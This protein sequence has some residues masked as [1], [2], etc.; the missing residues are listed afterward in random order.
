MHT[1]FMRALLGAGLLVAV[2]S[3]NAVAQQVEISS[4]LNPVGSGARA[5]G[6][7]G[8]FIGVADDA[9]AA[10]WNP[11]GLARLEKPEF[12]AAFGYFSRSQ[13][14]DSSSHPELNGENGMGMDASGLNYASYVYPFVGFGRNMV[15]SLNYQRM[16]DMNK[17][18][19]F[20]FNW[21]QGGGDT[22]KDQVRFTQ[23][24]YLSTITPA[25]AIQIIPELYLGVAVNIWNDLLG[26]CSWEQTYHSSGIGSV[27]GVGVTDAVLGRSKFVF[28]GVNA[29]MG[30]LLNLSKFTIGGVFKSPFTARVDHTGTSA[31]SGTA[32]PAAFVATTNE[33]IQMEMPMSYGLGVAYRHNDSWTLGLDIYQTRWSDF[34]IRSADGS[35]IN[36]ITTKPLSQGRLPDTTQVRLGSEYLLVSG[37]SVFPLRAGIFYD[38]EPGAHGVDDFFGF[39]IGSGYSYK[40]YSFDLAYQFRK[41]NAVTGDIPLDGVSTT[42]T[43]HT[44]LASLIYRY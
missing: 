35:E 6:M 7:G 20:T 27:G 2:A 21:E 8:A 36:P 43:E 24:G 15:L 5:L 37:K 19:N 29:N 38:P 17:D 1:S 10:S 12:S 9:T 28:S 4:S 32:I 18:L 26:T 23:K 22:L 30:F 41:G 44:L 13:N 25:I 16:F 31:Q 39:S 14:Y 33:T 34:L 11:A 42:I 3:P 40:D